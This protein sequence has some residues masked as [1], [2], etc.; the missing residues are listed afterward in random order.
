MRASRSVNASRRQRLAVFGLVATLLSSVFLTCSGQDDL[1]DVQFSLSRTRAAAGERAVPVVLSIDNLPPVSLVQGFGFGI[2]YKTEQLSLGNTRL[3]LG[4]GWGEDSRLLTLGHSA[5]D[6]ISTV[7]FEVLCAPPVVFNG[8][9]AVAFTFWP[10]LHEDEDERVDTK[11]LDVNLVRGT[12]AWI[13]LVGFQPL[14]PVAHLENGGIELDLKNGIRIGAAAGPRAGVVDVPVLISAVQPIS[15]FNFGIDYDEDGLVELLAVLPGGVGE[16]AVEEIDVQLRP[17]ENA[18]TTRIRAEINV[19]VDRN[20]LPYP[21][22]EV[23]V[24]LLRFWIKPEAEPGTEIAVESHRDRSRVN[25]EDAFFELGLITVQ[26]A[27]IGLIIRGDANGDGSVNASDPVAILAYLFGSGA[28]WCLDAADV[29][30]DGKI[31]LSDPTLLLWYLFA[32]GKAPSPPFPGEG[33]DPT[34][35]LLDSCEP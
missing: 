18:D 26:E 14:W 20:L 34:F 10:I 24:L 11:T 22:A 9:E 15:D 1:G 27:T 28:L 4:G 31:D 16:D 13:S 32:G 30:D 7:F 25:H 17:I 35:D 29:N 2:S 6:G 33:L 3:L 23:P 12:E 19:S 8:G 21:Q 5:Q